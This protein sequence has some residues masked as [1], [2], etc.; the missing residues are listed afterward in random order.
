MPSKQGNRKAKAAP[1]K[2]I[3]KP[4]NCMSPIKP[5]PYN[6][7][8]FNDVFKNAVVLSLGNAS[9]CMERIIHRPIGGHSLESTD[10]VISSRNEITNL[11]RTK[12]NPYNAEISKAIWQQCQGVLISK[13][14]FEAKGP[15]TAKELYI[16]GK[17]AYLLEQIRKDAKTSKTNFLSNLDGMTPI[18]K[19]GAPPA[20]PSIDAD[21]WLSYQ[22]FMSKDD[23]LEL[24]V[25]ALRCASSKD[26]AVEFKKKLPQSPHRSYID[27]T[28]EHEQ[29]AAP[30]LSGVPE[31][32]LISTVLKKILAKPMILSKPAAK[33]AKGEETGASED[34]DEKSQEGTEEYLKAVKAEGGKAMSADLQERFFSQKLIESVKDKGRKDGVK[35][36]EE[37][38]NY[39]AL[40]N[41]YKVKAEEI[42]AAR[43][44]RYEDFMKR[45]D[46]EESE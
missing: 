14:H 21:S 26:I 23:K 5:V 6:P 11:L 39:P 34:D 37:V 7:K 8:D 2:E 17:Q 1:A 4:V 27:D 13:G 18:K 35:F 33:K 46:S 40:Y 43:R 29:A 24:A 38:Q 10:W 36:V 16:L 30:G 41:E 15:D 9:T 32:A 42:Q 12:D 45:K 44:K 22:A 19:G 28:N 20:L 3:E 25:A 31:R